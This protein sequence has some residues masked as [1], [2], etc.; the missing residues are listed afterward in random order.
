MKRLDLLAIAVL[1][2][3]SA[4]G[5]NFPR[6]FCYRGDAC[7]QCAGATGSFPG[8]PMYGGEMSTMPMTEL[9][10]PAATTFPTLPTPPPPTG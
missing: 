2:A 1:L 4:A 3:I 10:G 5:C 8:T 6:Q 9:P 7:D